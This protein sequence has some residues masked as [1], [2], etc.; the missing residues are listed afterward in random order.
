MEPWQALTLGVVEGLTEYLPVS[1][2]GHLLVTQRLMGIE[3]GEAANAYAIVIQAGAIA[4]VL[5]IYRQRVGRVA[6]GLLGRDPEGARLALMLL[7]AFLPAAVIGLLTEPL[8]ESYLF[9]TVPVVIAWAVGGVLLLVVAP[10][11]RDAEG[12]GIEGL[13]S[14]AA[15]LIGL[16]QCAALWPGVSRSM[17]TILGGLAVGLPL[18]PAVEFSFLLGLV[19]LGAAT[20]YTALDSGS[21]MVASY[22]T[23]EMAVGFAA[24][25]ASAAIAV[26]WMVAWLGRH[27]LGIFGWWR[28]TAAL[29][30]TL[31]VYAGIL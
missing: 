3:S 31:L 2:T 20:A 6:L 18:V 5:G 16:A 9:G 13:T 12:V 17:A 30:A 8:I 28:L 19:T 21:A 7:L 27:G 23:A 14:R 10:R 11:L 4:A 1:S 29:V 22:G 24:S 15:I 25:W 26:K